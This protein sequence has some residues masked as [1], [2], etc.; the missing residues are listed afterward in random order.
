[1]NVKNEII[2]NIKGLGY[3]LGCY[4]NSLNSL[5]KKALKEVIKHLDE[6]SSDIFLMI[7]NKLYVVEIATVNNEKDIKLY[8]GLSYFRQYGNLED[9]LDN[10]DISEEVYKQYRMLI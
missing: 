4:D 3:E 7:R 5:T 8:D 9:A 1:M 10:N 2:K 6:E